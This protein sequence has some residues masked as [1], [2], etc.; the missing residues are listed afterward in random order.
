MT[1]SPCHHVMKSFLCVSHYQGGHEKP[2]VCIEDVLSTDMSAKAY[3]TRQEGM[4]LEGPGWFTKTYSGLFLFLESVMDQKCRDN[5]S[6]DI[7]CVFPDSSKAVMIVCV[8]CE[9]I[10]DSGWPSRTECA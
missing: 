4:R 6:S 3:L 7:V 9:D 1:W 5:S 2:A 8:H 10:H